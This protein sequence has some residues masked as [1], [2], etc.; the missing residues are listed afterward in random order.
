MR[1][2]REFPAFREWMLA[3]PFRSLI[4][5]AAL[6]MADDKLERFRQTSYLGALYDLQKAW[7]ELM[8]VTAFPL[9]AA[10]SDGF[11]GV[12]REIGRLFGKVR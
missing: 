9:A 2:Q 5:A 1:E 12:W 11:F 3:R 10:M 8:G 4:R 6:N 7:Y